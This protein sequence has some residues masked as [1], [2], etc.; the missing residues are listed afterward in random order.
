VTFQTNNALGSGEYY[1]G[2]AGVVPNTCRADDDIFTPLGDPS[3]ASIATALD[4]LGGRTCTPITGGGIQTQSA[5][6]I[7]V[8]QPQNPNAT[9]FQVPGVY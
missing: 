1:S 4:F 3:E 7:E 8:L 5:G 6:G 9:Q 2:L